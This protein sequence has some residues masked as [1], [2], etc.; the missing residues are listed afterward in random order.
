MQSSLGE[1]DHSNEMLRG[2]VQIHKHMN[3]M[4]GLGKPLVNFDVDFNRPT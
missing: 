2:A 1:G 3:G 4:R